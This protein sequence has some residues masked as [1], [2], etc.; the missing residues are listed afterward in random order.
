M[1]TKAKR[2]HYLQASTVGNVKEIHP[3]LKITHENM[4]LHKN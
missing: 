1:H 2:I 4:D 3:G